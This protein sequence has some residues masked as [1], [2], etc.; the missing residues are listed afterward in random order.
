[1]ICSVTVPAAGVPFKNNAAY[2]VGT[3]RMGLALQQEYLDH[4][5]LVQEAIRFRYIRGH[6]LFCD[7]M[8]IYREL[9]TT[10]GPRPYYN[11]TYLDRGGRQLPR[12]RH[13][14]LS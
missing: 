3:G 5:D 8:G 2:C 1:M 14:A 9:D 6:G 12:A 4:L 10:E 7:D 13:P 11:F